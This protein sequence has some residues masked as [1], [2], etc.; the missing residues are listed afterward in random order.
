MMR[1]MIRA[2]PP[3]TSLDSPGTGEC[4]EDPEGEARG[5]AAVAPQA[6]VAS[7]YAEGSEEVVGDG[8]D[9]GWARERGGRG[10]GEANEGNEED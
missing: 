2:P 8:P 9:E 1:P 6:V 3:N 10:E 5:V 4:K 7:G